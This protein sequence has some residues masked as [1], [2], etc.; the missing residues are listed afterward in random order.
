MGV[1]RGGRG[2]LAPLDFEIISKK[3][4]FFQFRG[5]KNKFHHFWPLWKKVW[6]NSLLLPPGKNPSD[7]HDNDFATIREMKDTSQHSCDKTMDDKMTFSREYCFL[8]CAKSWWIKFY[9]C[10]FWGR[11]SPPLDPP[12][13]R[14][15]VVFGV[16]SWPKDM[17]FSAFI[18]NL[19]CILSLKKH[20]HKW[21]GLQKGTVSEYTQELRDGGTYVIVGSPGTDLNMSPTSCLID[22]VTWSAII[23]LWK[24]VFTMLIVTSSHLFSYFVKT[25]SSKSYMVL[26]A[27]Q[28]WGR[29]SQFA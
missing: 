15:H 8:N 21:L 20:L 10:R 5:V 25:T 2:G 19:Y 7:A 23:K 18:L 6:E 16:H 17:L 4:L 27:K 11:R 28:T 1:G 13:S 29:K 24:A 26:F 14:L 9:F 22:S 3:R 12:L